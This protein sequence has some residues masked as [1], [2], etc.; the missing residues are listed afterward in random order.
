MA[1][2]TCGVASVLTEPD[3]VAA[4]QLLDSVFSDVRIDTTKIGR[5]RKL[6]LSRPWRTSAIMYVRAGYVDAGEKR[7]SAA[8]P[9]ANITLS[10]AAAA[11]IA[12]YA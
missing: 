3:F 2:N 1:Q 9:S 6:I 5:W 11:G 8:R 4:R 10:I 7:R 12:D